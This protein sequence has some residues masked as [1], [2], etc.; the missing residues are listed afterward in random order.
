M[1]HWSAHIRVASKRSSGGSDIRVVALEARSATQANQPWMTLPL[2]WTMGLPHLGAP[3]WRFGLPQFE[4]AVLLAMIGLL[5]SIDWI[6]EHQTPWA[7]RLWSI[8][9]VRWMVYLAGLY[10]IIFFGSFGTVEFIY[11]QF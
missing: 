8:R 6:E 4:F 2:D 3:G 10:S 11:F 1:E 9:S 7:L 5:F